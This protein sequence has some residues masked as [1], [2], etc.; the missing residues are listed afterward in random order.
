MIMQP[1]VA[2]ATSLPRSSVNAALGG[3]ETAAPVD[4]GS[5][6]ACSRVPG[7]HRSQVAHLQVGGGVRLA[8]VEHGVH[9][10]AHH[11]VE[12]RRR[13]A[14]VD[15]THRVRHVVAGHEAALDVARLHPRQGEAQQVGDARARML[16]GL[17]RPQDRDAGDR[18]V[19][20][21]A[22]SGTGE[23]EITLMLHAP[24]SG[25]RDSGVAVAGFWSGVASA[26]PPGSS[27]HATTEPMIATTNATSDASRRPW[28][29]A[30]RAASA[31]CCA[32]FVLP[33]ERAVVQRG[34]ERVACARRGVRYPVQE[35]GT[36]PGRGDAAHDGH[37]ERAADLAG[38]VVDGGAHA[39]A[40]RR[41]RTHDRRGGRRDEQAHAAGERHLAEQHDPVPGVG[42]RR[43]AEELRP[44]DDEQTDDD[45][46]PGPEPGDRP[47]REVG[48]DDQHHRERHRADPR[49]ER[50]VTHQLLQLQGEQEDGAEEAEVHRGH[51]DAGAGEARVAEH[52]EVEHRLRRPRLVPDE[53][54]RARADRRRWCRACRES[55]QPL[56]PPRITPYTSVARPT[57]DR[58]AP[59]R[60]RR[61]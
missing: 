39:G 58:S 37:A 6:G 46:E 7:C 12:Q 57:I 44:R 26:R 50:A 5:R 56:L 15:R 60:S 4:D 19:G 35:V 22:T 33:S 54:A 42:A 31:S 51:R 53:H 21:G 25:Y 59:A 45:R 14:T 10:A 29:N 47:R 20:R 41:D 3:G 36:E 27:R 17:D 48:H 52:A 38:R 49:R 55:S 43:D 40:R 28:M 24:S 23:L 61:R 30:W 1:V 13:D 34:A 18:L 8:R 32:A 11:G 9:R 16:T 2:C